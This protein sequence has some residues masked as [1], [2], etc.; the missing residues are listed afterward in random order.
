MSIKETAKLMR[1]KTDFIPPRRGVEGQT[2]HVNF[3]KLN[4]EEAKILTNFQK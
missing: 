4:R 3:T 1:I 2:V